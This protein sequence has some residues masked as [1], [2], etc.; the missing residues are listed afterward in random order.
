GPSSIQAKGHP[1]L[2]EMKKIET[3]DGWSGTIQSQLS[4]QAFWGRK[5]GGKS[6]VAGKIKE[7]DLFGTV[8]DAETKQPL[9]GANVTIKDKNGSPVANLTADAQ[10]KYRTTL[11]FG[12]NYEVKATYDNYNEKS[13]LVSLYPNDYP[14]GKQQ[15]FE[16][17]KIKPKTTACI[18]GVVREQ[19]TGNVIA[20]ANVK[21]TDK[22]GNIIKSV[23]SDANG[24]YEACD[25]PFGTYDLQAT[26][27]GYMYNVVHDVNV[28]PE[29]VET[30]TTQD[31]EL[32][33][34]EVG[35]KIVLKDIYYDVAKATLRD[36]SVAELDRLVN[37][38]DQ[39]PT[40]VIEIGGHTDSDGSESYNQRLS[41]ARSQSVVDYLLDASIGED[42]MEAR[43]YGEKE[44]I[45]P[46]DSK[47]NK[48][49][50]RR[51][52]FKVLAF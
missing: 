51:T 32:I 12:T 29:H 1:G 45:V 40:L 47:E 50:N 41:Q 9:A 11:P 21:V 36:E 19:G 30:G 22:D 28:L 15:N 20:D 35:M 42:R 49:K 6:C 52:E 46:N 48:Q 33:K 26:R 18:K 31:I 37:I 24:N 43:G 3:M 17:V 23:Q 5:T 16:L 2:L 10:G 27:K 39:N 13:A 44:P 8:I 34:F 4:E 38:M 14:Q 7:T 25:V